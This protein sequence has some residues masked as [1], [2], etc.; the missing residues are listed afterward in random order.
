MGIARG[1]MGIARV[2]RG[3]HVAVAW[4]PRAH[5][6]A[7]PRKSI[8]MIDGSSRSRTAVARLSARSTSCERFTAAESVATQKERES[9][10]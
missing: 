4:R 1:R 10:R 7:M 3:G 9:E 8:T 2:T 6:H 5:L